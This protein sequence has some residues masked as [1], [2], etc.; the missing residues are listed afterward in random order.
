MYFCSDGSGSDWGFKIT[1][2]PLFPGSDIESSLDAAAMKSVIV[3]A[4]VYDTLC[5]LLDT[6]ETSPKIAEVD[7]ALV[8][9]Q[10]FK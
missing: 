9:V 6:T 7:A 1:V 4:K 8:Q 3:L 2:I 5:T 10:D